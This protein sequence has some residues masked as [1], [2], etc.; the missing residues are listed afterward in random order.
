M[1]DDGRLA[2]VD[3]DSGRQLFVPTRLG[4]G[5]FLI[6]AYAEANGHPASD[7]PSCWQ[8]H[9]PQS[10]EPLTVEAAV[11]AADNPDQ[12]FTIA[13]QGKKTYAIRNGSAFLRYSRTHG[14]I[15]E[16][17]GD[18]PLTTTFRLVDNGPARGTG[19]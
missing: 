15:L 1:V 16:E 12:Q 6:K 14:L 18:A 19:K 8:V 11:C 2:E 17:L 5:R 9:N 13:A 10:T 7:E 3:D 4:S